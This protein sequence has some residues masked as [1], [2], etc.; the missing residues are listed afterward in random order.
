MDKQTF[1]R[2][3]AQT[4]GTDARRA[5]GLALVVL[6]ELRRRLTPNEAADVAAQLP[7]SLKRDWLE[8]ETRD[9]TVA[10]MHALELVG[11][12]RERAGLPDD[13]EAAR[14]VLAVF[15][16]LQRVLGSAS[17]M[18]GEAWD[19]FS[20]LPKDLKR[21]WLEAADGRPGRVGGD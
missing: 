16:A 8:P 4:V 12:V 11:R 14:A 1:L 10:K 9:R 21:L 17:G 20:Q 7:V 18:E 6:D 2:E 5:E 3:I 15:H 13:A 19:V